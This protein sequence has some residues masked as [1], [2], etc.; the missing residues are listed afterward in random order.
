MAYINE[1]IKIVKASLIFFILAPKLNLNIHPD[2]R[3][4]IIKGVVNLK[5]F[6]DTEYS[7]EA[8][9][10]IQ[11]ME[12]E[13]EPDEIIELFERDNLNLEGE[14]D[15]SQSSK[16]IQSVV[17]KFEDDEEDNFILK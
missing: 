4:I 12:T 13:Q 1:K 8:K 15:L 2:T 17:K 3:M 6:K 5:I 11:P 7:Y 10:N 9:F 14:G 16:S